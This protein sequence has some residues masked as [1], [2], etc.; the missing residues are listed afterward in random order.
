MK[1]Q[2]RRNEVLATIPHSN[3]T[4]NGLFRD[5]HDNA[6]IQ[7]KSARDW[8]SVNVSTRVAFGIYAAYMFLVYWP[9]FF[10]KRFFWEDF[11]NQ[12]Y[13][14]RE[15]SF[16]M[17][18]I[19]HAL[20]FWNPYS[21]AW[22]PLLADA[23]NGFWYPTNLLQILIT[24]LIVP[25][26]V[27]L[28]VLIPEVMTLLHLPLA[29]LGVFY[30]L[31]KQFGISPV[32]ALIA[33]LTWGFGA[34][35]VAEQNHSMQIIQLSLLPWETLLALS[36]AADW[37]SS[38]YAIALGLLF[39]ISFFA[40]QPQT[41]LFIA[42]FLGSWTL[43][44]SIRQRSV[45][46][47]V[48]YSLAMIIAA[49]VSA[50]QLLPSIE[51]TGL[52]A[53]QHL[54]Y[55]EA[56]AGA[57]HLGHLIDYFVPKYYGEYPGFT[58]PK[59]ALVNDHYWYWE[60]TYY[61]GVLAE[62]LAVYGIVRL[63]K[64]RRTDDPKARH[65]IFFVAFS[66]FALAYGMGGNLHLQWIFWRFVPLFDH[67]R[68]PNRMLWFAWF[69]GSL[70]TGFGLEEFV[71]NR[72]EIA[73]H[74]R[75][76]FWS[77]AIFLAFNVLALVGVFDYLFDP[78]TYRE[79]L[80]LLIFHSMIAS[81]I[82]S[83]YFYCVV[84]NIIPARWLLPI[85]GLLIVLDL[86]YVDVT[87]HRNTLSRETVVSQDSTSA[88]VTYLKHSHPEDH[89]KLL[90]KH[91]TNGRTMR[92][93]LG[94]FLHLPIE[95]DNN[96]EDIETNNPLSLRSALPD[97]QDSIRRMEILGVAACVTDSTH[98]IPYSHS[99]PFA[100]LY[101]KW[102]IANNATNATRLL[103]DSTFD[104]EKVIVLDESPQFAMGTSSSSVVSDTVRIDQFSEN[105]L[106]FTTRSSRNSI[107]FVND[108]Y[109]P[110][111]KATVDEKRAEVLRA[112]TS[113]RAIP[114]EAGVHRIVL[115]Y[116]SDT[117]NTGR[118]ITLTTIA[119]SLLALVVGRKKKSL[120]LRQ[121]SSLK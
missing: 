117:F 53:R 73:P 80:W 24:R 40:G 7:P 15:F 60:A 76:F 92:M 98:I 30:L 97:V 72:R 120:D 6:D 59:S 28:P 108:L 4:A 34:R 44:E 81:V 61:W 82:V 102:I 32:V 74:K 13:P 1:I 70:A 52:S 109:Y 3:D 63:W 5:E 11:F 75:F 91:D 25:T 31:K 22:A 17:A 121:G 41:F 83:I 104:F 37:K 111:W 42:I 84:R 68:A 56:G 36:A 38:R 23:Q 47:L 27:H 103:N 29:A 54:S 62:I 93:N 55:D 112:F 113:L 85:A 12:E 14:I 89:A 106:S 86:Y 2:N 10:G 88:G 35:M 79:G 18:G 58:I 105:N 94:M 115:R 26:A 9:V 78:H 50:I 64:R 51:L 96:P 20:P 71:R 45:R 87:W 39:G 16:Y 110:A 46:P 21:F 57:L 118:A 95:D 8:L 101:D 99:L 114:V 19:K 119:L 48:M 49:G 107:L 116:D 69:I 67:I 33:G 100:K 77:C 66:A 65:L 90:V 43:A